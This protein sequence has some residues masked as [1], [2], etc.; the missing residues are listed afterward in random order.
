MNQ[1]LEV[2]GFPGAWY[3]AFH[4]GERPHWWWPLCRPGF[5]HVLAFGY[6]VH[7]EA[8]LVYDVTLGRTYVRAFKRETFAGWLDNLP[9]HRTILL[10][11]GPDDAAPCR[12]PGFRAGFWCTPAVAHLVGARSRALRPEALWR[13]LIAQG[14]RPAFTSEPT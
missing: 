5:R 4:D 9:D 10:V 6:C 13:D 11:E 1:T 12:A 7:A 2:S 3:V 14:A 8:W